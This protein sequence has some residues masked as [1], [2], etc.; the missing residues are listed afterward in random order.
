[1]GSNYHPKKRLQTTAETAVLTTNGRSA[2]TT[3]KFLEL[4]KETEENKAEKWPLTTTTTKRLQMISE[5]VVKENP[6]FKRV[7][8]F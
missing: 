8:W 6:V 2:T 4:L 1:M 7:F 3:T 5:F